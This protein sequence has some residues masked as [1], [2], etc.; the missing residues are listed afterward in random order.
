MVSIGE[1]LIQQLYAHGVRHIFGVPG[2]Y[3]LGF[4]DQLVRSNLLK[5]VNT[6]DEQGAGIAADAYARVNGLGAVCITYA[7]GGF[8]VVNSTAQA[9]AEKSPVIVIS[10]A[11]GMKERKRDPLLHHKVRSFDAQRRIF[12]EITVASTLLSDPRTAAGEID[13]CLTESVRHK[14]PAYIELPRDVACLPIASD[15]TGLC[16]VQEASDQVALQEALEEAVAMINRAQ[17][18]VIVAGVELHRF[19]LQRQLLDLVE[20]TNIPIA[21]LL[22][23]KS[24]ISERHPLYLGLYEGA[25]GHDYI[26]EYVESSDCLV[27]LGAFLT[28]VELGTTDS[29]S[30][31]DL[32]K[33]INV[34]S[35]KLSIGYH[36]YE[37]VRLQDFMRGLLNSKLNP[38]EYSS[39]RPFTAV[40]NHTGQSFLPVKGQ[41]VTVARLFQQLD[42][43][44]NDEMVVIADVGDALFGGSD[45]VIH[46]GTEFLSPAYYLSLGFAI[47]AAVGAQMANPGLRP[48]VLVGDGAFQMTGIE[49]STIARYRLNPIIIVINNRGYGTERPMLDG[50]FNDLQLWQYSRIPDLIGGN[51]RGFFVETED[52]LSEALAA[53]WKFNEGYSILDIQIERDDMSPALRR[54]T[55][56]MAKK[57]R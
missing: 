27:M 2:D 42:S 12:E 22:L 50:P 39:I 28:D 34:T 35:E 51:G 49:V 9:Y 6:C 56:N 55:S 40:I 8:K 41:K 32:G 4:Y 52:Q 13:R 53:A 18:P 48:I 29:P 37:N 26:R 47:P 16:E 3:V 38:R 17:R 21:T 11:P 14:M 1:Y 57:V 20:S 19:G 7:V 30:K 23:S 43:F 33:T 25:L 44:L 45:L 54:L 24:V 36:N 10:G 5:M 46:Q 31:I 15:H